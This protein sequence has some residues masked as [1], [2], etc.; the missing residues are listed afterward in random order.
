MNKVNKLTHYWF[1]NVMSFLKIYNGYI[2]V[3]K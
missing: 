2:I 3:V 1:E